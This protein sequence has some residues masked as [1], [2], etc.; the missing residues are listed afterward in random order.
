MSQTSFLDGGYRIHSPNISYDSSSESIHATYNYQTT[1]VKGSH[2]YPIEK[3]LVFKTS[4][5]VPKLGLLLVGL[6]GNNGTTILGGILANKRKLSWETKDGVVK[7]NYFGSLTQAST[8]RLGMN[9]KGEQVYIPLKNL[10]PMVDP[11]DIVIHGWDISSS[12]LGVAMKRAKVL[13]IQLQQQLF[14][15]MKE[16][17]PMPGIYQPN[18]IAANQNERADNVLHGNKKQNLETIR[19]NI[20]DF[21]AKHGLDKVIVLWTANTERFCK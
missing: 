3:S 1:L 12:N 11:D 13:D 19:A 21:K 2:V 8:V 4:T 9:E 15:D 7:A 20:R 16:V 5:A 17:V 14:D 10:L 18:F 6:G